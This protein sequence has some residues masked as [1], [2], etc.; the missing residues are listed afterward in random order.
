MA[1]LTPLSTMLS[2]MDRWQTA[3]A[4]EEQFKVRDI[5][6][7]LREIR[8]NLSLPW[9]LTK[10]SLKVFT[11]VFEYPVA[12]DH[13]ELAFLDNPRVKRYE[14]KPRFQYLTHKDFLEDPSNRNQLAEI[15]DQGTK[16]L[17]VRYTPTNLSSTVVENAES[18]T[19]WSVSGDATA[20]ALDNVMYY[21]GSGSI[22]VTIVNSSGTATVTT[23]LTTT[24]SDSNYRKKYFFIR[25]YLDAAPT[26]VA[27]RFGNDVSNY[28]SA[29]VTTQ[30]SGQSFKADSWNYLAIDLNT[31]TETGT[32]S[33]SAFDYQ[34]LVFTGAASGTYFIDE[35]Y[36]REWTLM[37]YYYYSKY[38]VAL[39]GSSVAN[40]EYF[41]NSSEVYAT[42]TSL[43]GDSEWADLVVYMALELTMADKENDKVKATIE[44]KRDKALAALSRRYP[45]MVPLQS[46]VGWR[47]MTDYTIEQ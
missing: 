32:I 46:T 22:R 43:I 5:D 44:A 28:L 35:S 42:D 21:Q 18:A 3:S 41:F 39:T 24:I 30:F 27:L 19:G 16:Y 45:D 10:G 4:V 17:G 40:Q 13:D 2:R 34:A 7:V 29:S 47:F 6:T 37:D 9:T 26:S 1:F 20:V 15:W 12:T 11:D 38:M 23:A 36:L 31:A 8:W 14:D 25:V 33:S